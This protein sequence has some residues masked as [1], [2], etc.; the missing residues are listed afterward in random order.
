MTSNTYLC[1]NVTGGGLYTKHLCQKYTTKSFLVQ[2]LV[3]ENL[4][5]SGGEVV[6]WHNSSS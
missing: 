1:N 2:N 3:H 5:A 4:S 6:R